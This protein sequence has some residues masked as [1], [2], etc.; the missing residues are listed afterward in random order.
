MATPFKIPNLGDNVDAGEVISLFVKKGDTVQIDDPLMELETGKATIEV[1]ADIAGTIASIEVAVGDS[2]TPGQ[3]VMTIEAGEGGG[4]APEPEPEPAAEPAPAAPAA[5]KTES[6]EEPAPTPAPAPAAP[7][8]APAAQPA[9]AAPAAPAS[10]NGNRVPVAAAPSVRKFARE[11]GVDVERVTG[12]GEKGR[13]SID[14]VKAYA[15]QQLTQPQLAVAGGAPAAL[16]LPD[17]SQW[18]EVETQKMSGI[19]KVTAQHMARCWNTIPHVTQQ[20]KADITQ[21]EAARKRFG[22]KA[23]AAGGKLTLTA[24]LMKIVA[25]A[26]KVYP[27]FNASVDTANESIVLKKYIHIGIAVD[28]PKGLV[29]PVVRDVNK[30]NI[31]ELS[32]ELAGIAAK[33]RDGKISPDDMQG[34]SFTIS[35]LGGIGGSFFTPIV[36]H[37]EVAILGVGRGA[38]EPVWNDSAF[39][40]RLML[41]LSL[42]YDHRVIDGADG[43]R[44]I[45]WIAEAMQEPV[46]IALEG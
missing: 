38:Q 1:P 13:I 17:F 6:K 39:E 25:A 5:E 46:L 30:K 18:G 21:L 14:D 35:N 3:A 10:Y 2:V 41:P 31:I 34:G 19:R 45:R 12:T 27:Q 15:K 42:S 26:L 9:P 36:N 24:M 29:V 7:Q 33:A 8:A 28:T 4:A 37:P 40:P 44:F 22:A 43:A 16:P 20:E 32:A 11:I 23:E